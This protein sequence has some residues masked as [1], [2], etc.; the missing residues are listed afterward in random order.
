MEK[1]ASKHYF[2]V[3]IGGIGMQAIAGVLLH[4]GH[5]VTGSDINDF[6]EKDRLEKNGAKVIVGK[7]IAKN[8]P[9][10]IN[11]LI[12]T[13]AITQRFPNNS[14]P[15]VV[16]AKELGAKISKRSELV[17]ELM[18]DK[19]GVAV[20]GTHGKTTVTTL[21][22]LILQEAGLR[23]TALIGAEV[24]SLRGCGLV[25]AGK[26]MVVEACEYDRSFLDMNPKIAILTNI[27]EDHLDYYKDIKE[28]R[29][30]FAQ[31][32]SLVPQDGLVV[33]WGDDENIQKVLSGVKSK[34]VTFGFS[35]NNDLRAENIKYKNGETHFRLVANNSIFE[36]ID[37]LDLCIKLPGEYFILD[38]LAAIAVAKYLGVS[39]EVIKNVLKQFAG[40]K[41]RFE[42]LGKV[43]GVIFVDDYAHHPTEIQGMLKSTRDYFGK[44]KKI[45][46]VFQPHQFSR[47]RLL[48]KN[49]SKSFVEADE[50]LIAP[51]FPVRDS[52]EDK[53]S[54][55][56]EKLADAINQV[57][58]NA[59]A[60]NFNDIT[61]YLNDTIQPKD[62]ILSL[63]AG[64][65]NEWISHFFE[66]FKN[67]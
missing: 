25:G 20:S 31:F 66:E 17:G 15:E 67:D 44:D 33:A 63:G 4:M 12:Y 10:D 3:G 16:R 37:G 13:S 23:P 6:P 40:A 61:T 1:I 9:D 58:D 18:K 28:I 59:K 60:M 45:R 38:A 2:M 48:L 34:I 53:K 7:Q 32:L 19:I 36:E 51:I 50:V 8:V 41:R 39:G 27:E 29:S 43:N 21:I 22:S 56:S 62:V 42:I 14:H 5:K 55:S 30:T 26:Y 54:I 57:K 49:F 52:E 65:N 11:E 24:S 47:T 64:K 46:V 35:S